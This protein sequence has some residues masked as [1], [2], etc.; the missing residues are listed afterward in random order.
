VIFITVY[1]GIFAG[2]Q[3]PADQ[4]QEGRE[5]NFIVYLLTALLFT[6][7]IGVLMATFEV[8]YF[9]TFLRKKPFGLT[10]LIKT[11]FYLSNIFIWT[12]FAGLVMISYDLNKSILDEHVL[13]VLYNYLNSLR[14]L[15]TML[16]WGITIILS[17][18]ILQ[19]SDKFGQ[20]V[21]PVYFPVPFTGQLSINAAILTICMFVPGANIM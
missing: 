15:G 6:F 16:W 1:E 12:S 7:V 17:L 11:L 5:Y 9:N 14:L 3:Q 20:G 4:V 8:L 18:F 21:L 2:F 19:V 13:K 10:L